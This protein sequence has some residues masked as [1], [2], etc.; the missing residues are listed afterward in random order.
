MAVG[1]IGR[2][3]VSVGRS[4]AGQNQLSGLDWNQ[5]L[6]ERDQGDTENEEPR[7]TARRTREPHPFVST[8]VQQHESKVGTKGD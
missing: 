7:R 3:G 2:A 6:G 5:L 1:D 4:R 8:A